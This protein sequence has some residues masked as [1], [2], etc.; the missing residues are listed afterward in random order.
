VSIPAGIFLEIPCADVVEMAS[1]AGWDFVVIDTEH[2]PIGPAQLPDLLRAASVPAIVRVAAVR[3]E[4]IQSALDAGSDGVLVPQI[5]NAAEAAGVVAASRFHPRGR[6]GLNGF[7]RAARYSLMPM[8]EYLLRPVRVVIQI[9]TAGALAEVD[10]IA[11]LPGVDELFIGPYDL[12]QALGRPGDVMHAEVLTAGQRV[13][14]AAH[15]AGIAVSAFANS[16][17]A[18]DRWREMGI[19]RLYYS[20]DVYLLA[21]ALRD[22]RDRLR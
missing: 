6:R 7:V 21:Q 12:S 15:A 18:A 9:E 14:H 10:A 16:R 5:Q 13:I 22:V 2:G 17:E 4:L 3:N 20:A 8:E 11:A 19:D 1:L